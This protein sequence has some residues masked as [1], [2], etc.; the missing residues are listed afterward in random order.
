MNWQK[1]DEEE[2]TKAK[3]FLAHNESDDEHLV[4]DEHEQEKKYTARVERHK[5]LSSVRIISRIR[6]IYYAYAIFCSFP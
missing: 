2:D 3:A 5:S 6:C 4:G 1:F